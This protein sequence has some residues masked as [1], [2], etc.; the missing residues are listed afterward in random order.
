MENN[1]KRFLSL[2]LAFVMVL[3]MFPMMHAHAE[4]E[5]Y[6]AIGEKVTSVEANAT[7]VI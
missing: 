7:Y 5:T 4:E 2:L 3:G 1:F 6:F